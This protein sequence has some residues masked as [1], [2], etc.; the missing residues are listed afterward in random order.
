MPLTDLL[1]Y[2]LHLRRSRLMLFFYPRSMLLF[3]FAVSLIVPLKP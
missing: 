1:A 2:A 3:A